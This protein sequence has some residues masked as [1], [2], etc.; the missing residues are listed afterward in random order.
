MIILIGFSFIIC[1][2]WL[3]YPEGKY[4]LYEDYTKG[5]DYL[6]DVVE[7]NGDTINKR[8]YG[9]IYHYYRQLAGKSVDPYNDYG[10]SY[11]TESTT[12][13]YYIIYS[14]Y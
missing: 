8:F 14:V 10:V 11:Q 2:F 6:G 12:I 7:G 5:I 13:I 9:S 3:Q 1:L 4:P